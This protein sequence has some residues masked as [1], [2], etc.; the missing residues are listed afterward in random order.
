[1]LI[2]TDYCTSDLLP[3]VT[4]RGWLHESQKPI[5]IRRL[6]PEAFF[7]KCPLHHAR[8]S[9]KTMGSHPLNLKKQPPLAHSRIVANIMVK[10]QLA[11]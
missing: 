1:M 5:I 4:E 3:N 11:L 10:D 9:R 8:H 6:P 7:L 2:L